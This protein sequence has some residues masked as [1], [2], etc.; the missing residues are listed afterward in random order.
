MPLYSLKKV[1]KYCSYNIPFFVFIS[2]LMFIIG[3]VSAYVDLYFSFMGAGL[4]TAFISMLLTGYGLSITRDRINHGYRLPKIM[5]KEVFLFGIKGSIV[6]AIY[7]TFQIFILNYIASFF[8]FPLFNLEEMLLKFDQTLHLFFIHNPVH[9]II[10]FV[11]SAIVFY[12]SNFFGEIGLARLADTKSLFSAFNFKAIYR[13]IELFGWRHYARDL[14]SIVV[15]IVI[16]TFIQNNLPEFFGIDLLL[17]MLLGVLIFATQYLG[18]G[19]V[20][21]NIKDNEKRLNAENNL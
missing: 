11:L 12:V 5:P 20:Y 7:I 6:Y 16:L 14:T 18:I 3:L 21:C 19:A 8:G 15:A 10:F 9:S 2:V 4:I 1:W 13:S 17:W